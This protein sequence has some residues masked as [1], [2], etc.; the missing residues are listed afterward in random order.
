MHLRRYTPPRRGIS[1]YFPSRLQNLPKA[2]QSDGVSA[3]IECGPGKVLCGLN[4]K[5]DK[6]LDLAN[7]CDEDSLNK[8]IELIK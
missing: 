4:R 1:K 2:M 3:L 6:S 5:I 8:A 7:I